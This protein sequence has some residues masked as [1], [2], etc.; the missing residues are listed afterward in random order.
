MA[1]ELSYHKYEEAKNIIKKLDE[2]DSAWKIFPIQDI[3]LLDSSAR[4]NVP[5]TV[6][7]NWNYSADS[8][9]L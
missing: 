1:K 5:G 4:M 8:I 2:S 7:D 6:G 9:E 3:K